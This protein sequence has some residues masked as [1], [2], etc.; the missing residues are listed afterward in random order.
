MLMFL[1]AIAAR[2]WARIKREE[3]LEA[4]DVDAMETKPG[5]S[6]ITAGT[7]SKITQ[8]DIS[9]QSLAEVTPYAAEHLDS[10]STGDLS[11]HN[12]VPEARAYQETIV[13]T[14]EPELPSTTI[15]SDADEVMVN[16]ED[17]MPE[18]VGLF[19]EDE[20]VIKEDLDP[21][22]KVE[23]P[24]MVVD[25]QVFK[26]ENETSAIKLASPEPAGSAT[27][28]KYASLKPKKRNQAERP[29]EWA[30]PKKQKRDPQ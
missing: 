9:S 19:L 1:H 10:E 13:R 2:S 7:G 20:Q 15:H 22:L 8:L 3:R 11:T 26:Q 27:T 28:N 21:R 30:P 18:H 5:E 29:N 16:G 17:T 12:G 14:D 23:D 25:H 6:V 24:G 4:I